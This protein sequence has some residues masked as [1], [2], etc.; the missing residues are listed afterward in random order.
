MAAG[1]AGSGLNTQLAVINAQ[2][3]PDFP[4]GGPVGDRIGSVSADHVP[5]L[6][7]PSE[8]VV[9]AR[10]MDALGR[11]GLASINEG[12]GGAGQSIILQV[13]PDV[14]ARAVMSSPD[15]ASRISAELQAVMSI[16]SGRVPVYG[17][18]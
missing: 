17:R 6:A 9:T 7:T 2:S 4:V 14:V 11:E 18:G 3:P 1:I 15:L 10:G 8:G 13:G 12:S 5:I 16:T